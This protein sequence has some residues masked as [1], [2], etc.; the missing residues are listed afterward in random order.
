MANL[1]RGPFGTT[2]TSIT[3]LGFGAME[4]RA[5]AVTGFD[6]SAAKALLHAVLD[7]GISF[8]DTSPDYGESE[9]LIGEA[10]ATRRD[11]FFLATKCGC[12]VDRNRMDQR[13]HDFSRGNVRRCVEESL[14]R[15]RTDRLDLVQI[16]LSPSREELERNQSLDELEALRRE[17]K[18]RFIGMSGVLPNLV[19][20]IAMRRFDAFQIPYSALEPAHSDAISAAAAVGAGVI[21]RGSV[22]RGLVHANVGLPER[23]RRAAVRMLRRPQDL[24]QRARLN[25]LLDGMSVTEFMLRFTLAHRGQS[26]TIVGTKRREHLLANVKAACKGPLPADVYEEVRR[27][28]GSC[29]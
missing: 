14:R 6:R 20:H 27:R 2:G 10:I 24:W 8:I 25:E 7:C 29:G 1:P 19:D 12:P 15:L 4:L 16:H 22:Y 28:V 5:P 3:R 17:G 21:V 13:L 9:S 23:F 11:E 26:T 18:L